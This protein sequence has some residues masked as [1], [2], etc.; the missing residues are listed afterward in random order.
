MKPLAVIM[1]EKGIRAQ[2]LVEASGLDAKVVKAIVDGQYTPSPFQRQK[3]AAVLGVSVEEIAWGHSVP[4][5][6]LRGN[7]PQSGRST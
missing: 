6:H 7:G 5:Q 1:D 2:Q 3:L 4:V